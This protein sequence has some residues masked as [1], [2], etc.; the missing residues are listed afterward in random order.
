MQH[1]QLLSHVDTD[2]VTRAELRVIPA[3]ES[4]TTFH[5]IPH[6]ELVETLDRLVTRGQQLGTIRHDIGALD[7][8]MLFK[9]VCAAASA[10]AH[11]DPS[12][13]ERH[14]D[15]VRASI[16]ARDAVPLRGRTPT[17]EELEAG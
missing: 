14:M 5:P 13:I 10:F 16:T 4:T 8:L 9:G 6:A 17:L 2:L 11:L 15:L 3:P 7:V 12:L 1:G